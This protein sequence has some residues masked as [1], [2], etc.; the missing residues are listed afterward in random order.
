MLSEETITM[1]C[2]E[3]ESRFQQ[4]WSAE[5]NS[6]EQP[7]NLL[8]HYS[9]AEGL[10]GIIQSR[11]LW[12][13][14]ALYLNDT[15]EISDALEVFRSELESVPLNL[16][17]MAGFLSQGIPEYSE[18]APLDH[19]VVSFCEGGDLFSQWRGY[20]SQG[21][22][23]SIGFH[24][25]ALLAASKSGQHTLRGSC[26]LR[27]VKYLQNQKIELMRKRIDILRGILEPLRD[28][29]EPTDDLGL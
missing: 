27:R 3:V 18:Q 29:L 24:S 2:N 5:D 14:N 20:G 12:A 4:L 10:L 1:A 11:Q 8:Y 15:S 16:G 28:K 6:D 23:Y 13:T 17:E 7:P 26:T 25:S 21:T 9:S 19:F 22:G